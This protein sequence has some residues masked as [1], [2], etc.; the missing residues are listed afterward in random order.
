MKS[1]V[2]ITL[3]LI[4]V[5]IFFLLFRNCIGTIDYTLESARLNKIINSFL[6]KEDLDSLVLIEESH[7]WKVRGQ[8]RIEYIQKKYFMQEDGK[9]LLEN[10]EKLK[11][12]VTEKNYSILESKI[13]YTQGKTTTS[14]LIG[15]RKIPLFYLEISTLTK[16]QVSAFGKGKIALILDDWG[17]NLKNLKLLN[18][19]RKPIT[20]GVLPNLAY[21]R[22]ISELLP[23]MG[24]E[25]ILHL[26]LESYERK[27]MEK[28][29][30]YCYMKKN[31]IIGIFNS[32]LLS[33]PTAKGISNHMGSK[34][35]EDRKV[36]STLFKEM[37]KR[38][39]F[40]LDSLVTKKS[41]CKDLAQE[42]GIK[43]AKRDIFLDNINQ[44]SYIKN[45]L[46]KLVYLAKMNGEAIGVGHDRKLTIEVI[47]EEMENLVKED[48][49]FVYLSQMVK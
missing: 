21:S 39:L 32:A 23:E 9:N 15:K 45:Q 34:A 25:V 11:K 30:I 6:K 19:I 18:R 24:F 12:E 38:N 14:L 40:F 20:I 10:I 26:P 42:L 3:T 29:T 7:T 47:K 17:Y 22:K 2:K 49:E 5:I 33:V 13:S 48:I 27:N 46:K 8:S 37:K 43:I 44:K 31:E 36:M 16:K 28:D 1:F 4:V 41:I 35:T